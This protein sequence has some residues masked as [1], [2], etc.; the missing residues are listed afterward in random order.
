MRSR[1][2]IRLCLGRRQSATT[3]GAPTGQAR[4][5]L[6]APPPASAT[7]PCRRPEQAPPTRPWDASGCAA[8]RPS[9]WEAAIICC[10]LGADQ[11]KRSR[12]SLFTLGRSQR[13]CSLFPRSSVAVIERQR[14]SL[15]DGVPPDGVADQD[16][17]IRGSGRCIRQTGCQLA[18]AGQHLVDCRLSRDR[19]GPRTG[20][21]HA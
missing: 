9:A 21:R 15:G 6:A 20:T 17:G 12:C 2:A 10:R 14:R 18:S 7:L 13:D 4:V 5:R 8:S 1:D 19:Q 16:A 11:G 3:A